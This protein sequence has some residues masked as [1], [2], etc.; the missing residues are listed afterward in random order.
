MKDQNEVK[1]SGTINRLKPITTSTGTPMAEALLQVDKYQFRV[2]ALGNLAEGILAKAQDGD[3]LG[4]T[5]TLTANSWQD[6]DGQWRNSFCVTAWLV[7]I[8]G[9]KLAYQRG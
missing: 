2:T 4:V 9:E 3:R 1:L 8:H 5:G 6:K 7:E